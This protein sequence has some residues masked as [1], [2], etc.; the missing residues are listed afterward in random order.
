[1]EPRSAERGNSVMVKSSNHRN[2]ANKMRAPVKVRA[3]TI[4]FLFDLQ[5]ILFELNG[6][7]VASGGRAA[8]IGIA[9]AV[10]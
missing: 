9:L 2:F 1:M 6:L 10:F 4:Q 5:I 7:R 3:D 8:G